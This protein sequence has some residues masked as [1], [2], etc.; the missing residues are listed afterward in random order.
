MSNNATVSRMIAKISSTRDF[1]IAII[2]L[3]IAIIVSEIS[4]TTTKNLYKADLIVGNSRNIELIPLE[5]IIE[6]DMNKKLEELKLQDSIVKSN[7]INLV[8]EDDDEDDDENISLE[9]LTICYE[10]NLDE[11]TGLTKEDFIYLMNNM[12]YDYSGFFAENSELIY[13]LCEEN[14][15]NE[16]FFCGLIAAE[17]GWEIS[18]GHRN[19]NNYISMMG[20][21]GQMLKFSTVE[22]GLQESARLLHKDYLTEGGRYY[23][24]KTIPEIE[25]SFCPDESEH[26]DTLVYGCMTYI[27][28]I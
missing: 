8:E 12:K 19:T 15:I 20:E 16:I 7:S 26:W 24:G 18:P 21:S 25:K 28:T 3:T 22:E 2:F 5:E 10:D 14:E 1:N 23:H 13:D 17:C 27:A 11:R 6:R 9:E 4:F